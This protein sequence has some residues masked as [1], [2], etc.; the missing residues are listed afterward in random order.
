MIAH[1]YFWGMPSIGTSL[2][3]LGLVST[4]CLI[5]KIILQK[6]NT[7]YTHSQTQIKCDA[8]DSTQP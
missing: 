8:I 2:G 5:I 4:L 1:S 3:A 7:Q 6:S